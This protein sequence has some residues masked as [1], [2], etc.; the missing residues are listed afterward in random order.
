MI[1]VEAKARVSSFEEYRKIARRIGKYVGRKRKKDDYYTLEDLNDYPKKCLRIR[2]LDGVYQINFK[3][4]I[5]DEDNVDAK[6]ETEFRVSN[7]K[8]FLALLEEFGFKKWV[9]KEKETELYEIRK[10]FHIEL[11]KVKGLGNFVEIEYLAKPNEINRSRKEVEKV[12]EKMGISKEEIVTSGYTK[13][14]WDR[15]KR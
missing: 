12:L 14:L 4:R 13:L 1:E 6:K 7:I 3:Q 10:N 11:N 2:K 8:D 5:S 9:T 15:M